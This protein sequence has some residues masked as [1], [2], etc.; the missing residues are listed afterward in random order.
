MW[1]WD[2]SSKAGDSFRSP[3]SRDDRKV[4]PFSDLTID[5]LAA[6]VGNAQI[7]IGNNS[8]PLHLACALATP[9]I[10]LMGP[11]FPDR[12]WPIGD[13]HKVLRLGVACSP[14]S[15]GRCSHHTCLRAL[16]VDLVFKVVCDDILL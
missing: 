8:G 2:E 9:T 12:W 5:Q 7:F 1:C 11:T 3:L 15:L 16:D 14:C 6:V 10:S 4:I 13:N